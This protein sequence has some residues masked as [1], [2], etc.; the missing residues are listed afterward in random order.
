MSKNVIA[1]HEDCYR[2]AS[3]NWERDRV[4][5][6]QMQDDIERRRRDLMMYRQQIDEA[7]G[8]GLDGFDRERFLKRRNRPTGDNE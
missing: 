8:R 6:Q 3:E 4:R 7:K 1:W 5:V 2:N